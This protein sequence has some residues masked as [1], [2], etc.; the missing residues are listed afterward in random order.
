MVQVG[1]IEEIVDGNW[2]LYGF[3][4]IGPSCAEFEVGDSR[5]YETISGGYE[6]LGSVV[7]HGLYRYAPLKGNELEC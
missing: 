3:V 4:T 6:S 1:R 5:L 2:C 7:H